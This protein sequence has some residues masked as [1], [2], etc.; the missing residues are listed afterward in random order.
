MAKILDI[1][2]E[3]KCDVLGK[4][5]WNTEI[6]I[7]NNNDNNNEVRTRTGHEVPEGE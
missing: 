7:I 1:Y 5:I 3:R 2:G 4:A 6:I